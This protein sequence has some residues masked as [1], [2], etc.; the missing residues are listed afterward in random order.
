MEET[1]REGLHERIK[2]RKGIKIIMEKRKKE[3][4]AED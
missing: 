3:D 4:F 1:G 2:R